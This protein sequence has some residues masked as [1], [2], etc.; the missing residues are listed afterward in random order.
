VRVPMALI[1]A[2]MKLDAL[3]P[4]HAAVGLN[5]AMKAKGIEPNVR[6]LK[7]DELEQ[8]VDAL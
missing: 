4:Q 7:G 6:N 5:D 8:L 1:R 2:G 3:I